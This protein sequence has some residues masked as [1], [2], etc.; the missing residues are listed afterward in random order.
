MPWWFLGYVLENPNKGV[1]VAV[2]IGPFH[3]AADAAQKRAEWLGLSP[4]H[5]ATAAW[6]SGDEWHE[7]QL[8]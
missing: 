2:V 3:A 1:T 4:A 7:G 6:F 8:L 5:S